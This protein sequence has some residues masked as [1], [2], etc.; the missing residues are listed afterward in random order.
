M[1]AGTDRPLT[2]TLS[3]VVE[4][5]LRA[6]YP[7]LPADATARLFNGVDLSRFA[8]E[9]PAADRAALDLSP[10]DVLA[11]FVSNNFKL[12]GLA[13]AIEA[14]AQA[15]D[16]RLK[17]A[18]VGVA[19]QR[20]YRNLAE[21]LDVADRV[22]W[23]GG[24]RDLPELYRAADALVLPTYR[25]SCSLVVLEALACGLPVISTR[26]NGATEVMTDGEHGWI[27]DEPGDPRLAETLRKVTDSQVR[28][29]LRRACVEL[30]PVLSWEHHLETLLG[31]YGRV[32]RKKGRLG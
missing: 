6:C 29:R 26:Q 7:D 20:P 1:L 18:V 12:K 31:L 5:E 21:R 25:D 23:L 28:A 17:L 4:N 27:L 16:P 10:D 2:L 14:L 19:E 8:P 24:R 11:L 13:E 15:A 3:A 9:G 30:R 32:V 22:R